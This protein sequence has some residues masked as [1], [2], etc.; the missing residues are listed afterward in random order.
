MAKATKRQTRKELLKTQDR[1]QIFSSKAM[2]W[3]RANPKN[4]VM[5]GVVLIAILAGVVWFV[6]NRVAARA[7]IKQLY[8]A[9]VAPLNY[10]KG[11]IDRYR[12]RN[13]VYSGLLLS[14]T[15]PFGLG[16]KVLLK[17]I[18]DYPQDLARE[19]F[20]RLVAYRPSST[21]AR[22]ALLRLAALA[23]EQDRPLT[24]V[25]YLRRFLATEDLN[26]ALK[27]PARLALGQ[28]LEVA[29]RLDQAV[30]TFA[31]ITSPAFR[32]LGQFNQTRILA[33]RARAAGRTHRAR[34][35]W[36]AFLKKYPKSVRR[37]E[38]EQILESWATTPGR[39][40]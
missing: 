12:S 29:G 14:D 25:R 2:D 38:V 16:P 20:G 1:F 3:A 4:V 7:Q 8:A 34:D 32:E 28:A 33:T 11:Y 30:K 31:S 9:A 40:S 13:F 18:E 27:P 39:R 24:A 37:G 22:L 19:L 26:P 5:A 36:L 35:L 10:P 17:M 6:N 15:V 21:L 23:R